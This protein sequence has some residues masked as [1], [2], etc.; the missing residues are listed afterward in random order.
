MTRA[1]MLA[2]AL[3]CAGAEVEIVGSLGPGEHVYPDPPPGLPVIPVPQSPFA[4]RVVATRRA[5][6]GAI[7]YAVK[8][9]ATSL[10]V[11]LLCRAGRPVWVDVDDWEAI[12]DGEPVERS[13][14]SAAAKVH[15]AYF[16]ARRLARSLRSLRNLDHSFHSRRMQPW[17]KR[18]DAVTA[19]T[20]FLAERYGATYLPSGKDT[21]VFDPARYDADECRSQLGLGGVR[22]VMFPGT[23]RPHKGLEDVLAAFESLSWEDARLVLVG[24]REVGDAPAEELARRW[25]RY[26]IRLPR[27]STEQMPAV[28]AAAHVVVAPQRDTHAARAQFPMKLTDA[29]AMAKPIITTRVGDI[30]EVLDGAAFVVPPSSPE[31]IAAALRDAFERPDHARRLGEEARRRCVERY[32]VEALGKTLAGVLAGATARSPR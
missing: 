9:R 13:T 30:P 5:A 7:L 21:N 6:S 19:N 16:R 28:V 3:E 14:E 8:P 20:R 10:G 18:A 17:M 12:F 32:S 22:V 29:M 23:V 15:G 4:R 11:A 2:S 24:G 27:F 31:A 1:Y 25:P 26:V